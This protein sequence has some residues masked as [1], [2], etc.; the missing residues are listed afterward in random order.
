[1]III[2][3]RRPLTID[4]LRLAKLPVVTTLQSSVSGHPG[5]LSERKSSAG[6]V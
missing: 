5:T 6:F 3:A 2:M 1:M 4:T